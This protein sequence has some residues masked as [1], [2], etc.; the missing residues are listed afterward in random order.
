MDRR[1][2]VNDILS[3][4]HKLV[5]PFF[6]PQ[7]T[8]RKKMST[9]YSRHFNPSS[10]PQS[11]KIP[12][13][14][15]MVENSAGGVTFK[16]DIW[17]QARRFLILGTEGGSYY[18]TEKKMTY[19]AGEGLMACLKEDGKR[20]VKLVVDISSQARAPKNDPAIFALALAAKTGDEATKQ[21]AYQALP[22]VCRIGTHLFHFVEYM[23]TLGGWGNGAK[24]AISRW[25]NRPVKDVAYQAVKYQSRDGW[26]HR[27]LLRLAHIKPP[28]DEHNA[29]FKWITTGTTRDLPAEEETPENLKLVWAFERA[30]TASTHELCKLIEKYKLP[31]EAL[32]TKELSKPEIWEALLPHMGMTALVRSLSILTRVGVLAPMSSN[33]SN[34]LNRLTNMD[35][36]KKARVHPIQMLTALLT[37]KVGHGIK[38]HTTWVP[39]PQVVDAL[40]EGFYT[41]FGLVE[42][43]NLRHYIALDISSSMNQGMIAGVEGLTPRVASAAMAML[44]IRL[45]KNWVAKGFTC[46]PGG[47]GGLWG[48]GNPTMT[49]LDISPKQRLDQICKYVGSL[50]MGGTDCALPMLDAAKHKIPVDVFEIYTDCE[51]WAGEIHPIQALKK[52]RQKTGIPAKLVVIGMISTAFTIADPKDRGCLDVIGFD[53]A[54]PNLISDFAYGRI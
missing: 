28:T 6:V 2:W 53:T 9:N 38:G 40:D 23:Q 52:Y 29:L 30:K 21:A 50:P 22:Q 1:G 26:S 48:G 49:L 11:K 54:T 35:E 25:Y 51:T 5:H 33:L 4:S 16:L 13:R 43:T 3:Q 18:A 36:L 39:I 47:Y 14:D 12:G 10:T 45:E 7:G 44:R 8:E 27:D 34:T 15:D 20:L 41:S 32:P 31:R 42:P 46:A 37:Y 24:R 19:E 17:A